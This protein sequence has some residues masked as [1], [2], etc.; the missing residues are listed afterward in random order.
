MNEREQMT[1]AQREL[2][3][4]LQGVRPAM[5]TTIDADGSLRSRPMWTQG[6]TFDGSLW[7]F[8]ADDAPK[9]DELARNPQVG[10]SYAAPDKDLYVSVSG[11]AKVVRDREKI[12]E[13]WNT[14]AEAW[15]PDGTDDPHLALI[16]VDVDHAQYWEDKKPKVLQLAEILISVVRDVP[17]KSGDQGRIDL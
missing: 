14:F 10:L 2:W 8:S 9:A 12:D 15:F 1:A 7:F 11:R 5:M 16:R 4:K 3:D 17:P 13:L 6:D